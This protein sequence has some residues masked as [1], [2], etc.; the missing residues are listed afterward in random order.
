[1]K[2]GYKYPIDESV[3]RSKLLETETSNMDQA[4]EK[5][6]SYLTQQKPLFSE[7]KKTRISLMIPPKII[8]RSFMALAILLPS[9]IFYNQLNT[10]IPKA[11]NK[12]ASVS[13]VS[14]S[15]A[16]P[17]PE[18]KLHLPDPS[19]K[20]IKISETPQESIH[21]SNTSKL[22]R[23]KKS[24]KGNSASNLPSHTSSVQAA[25]PAKSLE[26]PSTGL[27]SV[28]SQSAAAEAELAETL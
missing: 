13:S 4:W 15:S 22:N 24:P 26:T 9:L 23:S 6:E 16:K 11:I 2:P 27:L 14:K 25:V 21:A 3:L 12:V 10:K 28:P 19:L 7:E 20:S 18:P 1:M 17:V 8:F 5:F